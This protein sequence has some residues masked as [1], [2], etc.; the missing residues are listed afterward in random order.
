MPIPPAL[1][2]IGVFSAYLFGN[3]IKTGLKAIQE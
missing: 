3:E 1:Y 2:A